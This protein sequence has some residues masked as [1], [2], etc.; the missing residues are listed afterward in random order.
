MIAPVR[1]LRLDPPAWHTAFLQMLPAITRYARCAFR[2]LGPEA[3]QEAVEEAVANACRAY[4]RLAELGKTELAY[5]G[6][7]ARFAVAQIQ[8][9]RRVG[10]R[11]NRREVFSPEAQRR[12]GF[13]VVHLDALNG[14]EDVECQIAQRSP[15]PA[16]LAAGRMDFQAWLAT[17]SVRNRQIARSLA[18]GHTTTDVARRIGVAPGR[19]SQVRRE[20]ERSWQTFSSENLP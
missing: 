6:V 20:L 10:G 1:P 19:V 5:P 16:T 8:S 15:T 7:L 2:C 3:K 18:T 4:A 12:H 17:L 13:T 14:K 9:G 11:L